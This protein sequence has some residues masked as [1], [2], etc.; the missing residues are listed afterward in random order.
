MSTW[1]RDTSIALDQYHD[2][3][4]LL[5]SIAAGDTLLRAHLRWGIVG[6]TSLDVDY[7]VISQNIITLGLVTTIGDGTEVP[8][9][10]R[11]QASDQAPPTQRW[12]YWETRGIRP[13][14]VDGTSG[15]VGWID[16]GATESTDTKGQVLATGLGAGQTLNLWASWAGAGDWDAS[17]SVV[18][19]LGV[20][21]LTS[22]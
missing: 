2:G 6:V 11:T 18:L 17:G 5:T 1:I 7:S 14:Y 4:T 10:A 15:S 19:W 8:P 13:N 21:I 9:N 20:S 16:T 12:T 22:A 3:Y